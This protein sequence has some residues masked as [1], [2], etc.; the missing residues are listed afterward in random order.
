MG[1]FF[2]KIPTI[3][4]QI[5]ICVCVL[6]DYFFRCGEFILSSFQTISIVK[7]VSIDLLLQMKATRWSVASL[8]SLIITFDVRIMNFYFIRPP[9]DGSYYSNGRMGRTV[10]LL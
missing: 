6:L 8:A 4:L 9:K 7:I 5:V 1:L 10:G 3:K 2:R